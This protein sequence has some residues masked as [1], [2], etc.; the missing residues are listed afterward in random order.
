MPSVDWVLVAD[1]SRAR[2]LHLL[3]DGLL[4]LPTLASFIHPEGHLAPQ[5]RDSDVA[6]RLQLPG[7]PRSAVEPH[8]DR[9][10]VEATRFAKQL[11]ESLDRDRQQNRFD[12]LFVIAPPA[13]MGVLREAWPSLVR[14]RIA[15][16]F[17]EDL[18]PLPEQELQQRLSKL[19]EKC[20][21]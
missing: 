19:L 7:G 10:H 8:E 6:G 11:A 3:P 2:I 4:P 15:G 20:T 17:T 9:W 21:A 12:R 14:T 1:R 13:L 5:D 16:E 18:L